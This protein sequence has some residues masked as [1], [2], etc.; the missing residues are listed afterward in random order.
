MTDSLLTSTDIEE[1]LSRAYVQAVAARAGYTT[2]HYSKD[3]DGIDM[4]I[5][6]WRKDAS[7]HRHT[8]ESDD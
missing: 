8:I 5:R 6:G 2:A 3:R 7:S 1:E 4:L